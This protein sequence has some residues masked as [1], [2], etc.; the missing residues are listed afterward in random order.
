MILFL[1]LA[2]ETMTGF[3][4]NY[5]NCSY[6]K[7]NE[8]GLLRILY[9]IELERVGILSVTVLLWDSSYLSI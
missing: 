5:E 9:E 1:K 6:L 3:L 8:N 7:S 2:H 4:W